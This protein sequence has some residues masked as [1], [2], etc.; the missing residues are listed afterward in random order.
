[1]CFGGLSEVALLSGVKIL[2]YAENSWVGIADLLAENG[3]V[4]ALHAALVK[5]HWDY[6][7]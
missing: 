2:A 4:A 6:W 7:F 1:M 3:V 5:L